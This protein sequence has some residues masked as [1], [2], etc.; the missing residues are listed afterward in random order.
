ELYNIRLYEHNV[1]EHLFNGS[2]GAP[3]IE[4]LQNGAKVA[5]EYPN[6][7]FYGADIFTPK[8]YGN[9]T[10]VECNI[11]ERLPF[12]D[13][14]FDYVYSRN[15]FHF[16]RNDTFQGFLSEILRI[17]KPGGWFE[18]TLTSKHVF[19]GGPAFSFWNSSWF[20][21]FKS[22]NINT[23][24]IIYL[25]DY[26][27]KTQKIECIEHQTVKIFMGNGNHEIGEF[28]GEVFLFLLKE[29]KEILLP[30]IGISSTKYQDLVKEIEIE[31]KSGKSK[32]YFYGHRIFGKKKDLEKLIY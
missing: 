17:L 18:V 20:W 12:P 1:F 10:F 11:F 22:N 4:K 30:F 3:V 27:Q 19:D 13:E 16:F 24:F 29:L 8:S 28:S 32:S 14:E 6:S 23:D 7:D 21:W 15:G 5:L 26:L 31:F 25:E 2:I 9:I